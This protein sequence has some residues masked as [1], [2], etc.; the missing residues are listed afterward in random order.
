MAFMDLL[1]FMDNGTVEARSITD[2]MDGLIIADKFDV[3]T[4]FNHGCRACRIRL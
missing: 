3:S 4:C 2:L 1:Q